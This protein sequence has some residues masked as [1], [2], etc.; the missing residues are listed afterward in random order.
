MATVSLLN[1][2]ELIK[3]HRLD[4]IFY[5]PI[6]LDNEKIL[7]SSDFITFKEACVVVDGPFGSDVHASEYTEEGIPFLRTEEVSPWGIDELKLVFISPEK[8][9]SIKRSEVKYK[10][11]VLTKTGVYFGW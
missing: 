1:K 8:H 10:D 2:S 6:Y 9:E 4:A 5:Q 7:K 3:G 11:V